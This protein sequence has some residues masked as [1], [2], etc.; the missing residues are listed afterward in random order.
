MRHMLTKAFAVAFWIVLLLNGVAAGQSAKSES[1]FIY[2]KRLFTDGL[3][4]LA[5]EA[6][7]NYIKG[8]PDSPYLAEATFLIG[9]ASLREGRF[10]EARSAFQRVAME[11]PDD[12]RAV[13]SLLRIGES[14]VAQGQK[15][16]A[17]RAYLRL[18]VFFPSAAQA[19][20]SLIRASRLLVELERW[21]DA[22]EPLQQVI[23][24][25]GDSPETPEARLLWAQV[26]ASRGDYDRAI[27]E[28]A[29]VVQ[30]DRSGK[31]A[32]EALGFQGEWFARIGRDKEAESAWQKILELFSD[33]P[34]RAAAL[35]RMGE[36]RLN[37]GDGRTAESLFR[38][39]LEGSRDQELKTRAGYGLGDAL[40]L[41]GRYEEALAQYRRLPEQRAEL[42]YRAALCLEELDRFGDALSSYQKVI[43]S[44]NTAL[45]IG[46][47]WQSGRLLSSL[48]RHKEARDS[49]RAAEQLVDIP[50]KKAEL[51]YLAIQSLAEH[52]P[53]E[54]L[55]A[56]EQYST[57]FPGSPR[58]DEVAAIRAELL[59]GLGRFKE[60]VAAWRDLVTRYPASPLVHDAAFRAEYL[61]KLIIQVGDPSTKVAGLLA[62]VAGGLNRGELAL[63]LGNIYLN[64]YKDFSGA[65][66]QFQIVAGDTLLKPAART[67]AHKGL[68][69]A[70]WNN[71]QKRLYGTTGERSEDSEQLQEAASDAGSELSR[72][73]PLIED[74]A[75]RSE[76]SY[77]ITRLGE[78]S[79]TGAD[80]IRFARQAWQAFL[81][82]Y[83]DSEHAPESYFRL[84]EAF[85]VQ[86]PGDTLDIFS[87][88]SVWYLEVL[89]DDF[90]NSLW[91]DAGLLLLADRYLKAGRG[92]EARELYER[93]LQRKSSPEKVVACLNILDLPRSDATQLKRI[94][95]W[96]TSEAWYNP[97]VDEARHQMAIHDLASSDYESARTQLDYLISLDPGVG[98]GL[99]VPGA[100]DHR[101]TYDLGRI[102]EGL[103]NLDTARKHYQRF[104]AHYPNAS[105]APMAH[106]KLSK[107]RDK[108]GYLSAAISDYRWLVEN[109]ID[110]RATREA[111]KAL[112]R[113]AFRGE[114]WESLLEW[115][116]AA[117]LAVTEP[118][119]GQIFGELTIVALYRL[120]KAT[121]AASAR[122]QFHDTYGNRSNLSDSEVRFEL[123]R[124]RLLSRTK[125]Y[126]Q[127]EDIYRRIIRRNGSSGYAAEASFELGRDLLERKDYTKALDLL[128]SMPREYPKHPILGQVLWVLGNYHVENG[129]LMDGINT[130]SRILE[131][132]QYRS[133][134]SNVLHNQ[135]Q[136]YK[137]AG[138]YAGAL[139]AN[140]KYLALYPDAEDAFNRLMDIG[141][142]YS[143]LGQYDL[144]ITQFRSIQPRAGV[145][146]EAACQYYIGEALEKSGRLAEAVIE[147]KKVDYLGKR[148]R[149]QWAVTAL[150]SAGRVLERL[151]EQDKA[152]EMY[153]EIVRRE[154]LASPFGRKAQEQIE[155]IQTSRS[156]P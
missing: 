147:Y 42:D 121:E 14:Y 3:Y 102:E 18:P 48:G 40:F 80:R 61:E 101:Y 132:E 64:D 130:Y 114:E 91:T 69:D 126:K 137:Q 58:V 133:I 98:A 8:Y 149:L 88:P 143:Q 128:T 54:A 89:R 83:P 28:A 37:I 123:E 27:A 146:D 79:R 10:E 85:S 29:R 154:G 107:I 45:Q 95:Q 49:Y 118:D 46:A 68:G 152:L 74:S 32:V 12:T 51:R 99:V 39:A 67:T 23:Q 94:S 33:A 92:G 122:K 2:A 141:L 15:E 38:D 9:D 119:T 62:E 134:W 87:D 110:S 35:V 57:Q 105:L 104:I 55:T 30:S 136:A 93:F 109:P 155:R 31:L 90:P 72:L 84:G 145:E 34:E 66:T 151:Q 138:F 44:G 13:Q 1:D 115:S 117:E 59:T 47:H 25:Y 106:L 148:T 150:Y 21:N 140:Q 108:Q 82:D 52:N 125:Q 11:Y 103:G 97:R 70:V 113:I 63:R 139:Q 22:E 24:Q 20:V 56:A 43:E 77:R 124:G 41:L 127:A 4:D 142:M 112:A 26:L 36:R 129:N 75:I 131:N 81:A 100:L 135:I 7:T 50:L 71:Y 73:L 78:D 120:A 17:A 16:R 144:A 6:L 53:L 5:N 19:S 60:A 111:K 116:K 86:V 156:E 76:I 153:A 96:L 65:I